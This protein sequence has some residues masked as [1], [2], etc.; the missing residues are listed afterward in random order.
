[1]AAILIAVWW[2]LRDPERTWGKIEGE[3]LT[4]DQELHRLA[5]ERPRV[6]VVGAKA[7]VCPS[8][9]WGHRAQVE[10]C[11]QVPV[12]E[13]GAA[14]LSR[15]EQEERACSCRQLATEGHVLS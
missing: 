6:V 12:S 14:G 5:G 7:P 11:P 1:M 9:C 15:L 13:L 2:S 4:F 10:L 3:V 8:V